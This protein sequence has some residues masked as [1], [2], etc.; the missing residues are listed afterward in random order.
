VGERVRGSMIERNGGRKRMR[1][2][3]RACGSMGKKERKEKN[4]A[5]FLP[6]HP[7]GKN[8][9]DLRLLPCVCQRVGVRERERV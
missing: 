5:F 4:N 1:V 7:P 2:C 3:V 8:V 6:S 9:D